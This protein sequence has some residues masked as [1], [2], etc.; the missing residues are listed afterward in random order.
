M[1]QVQPFKKKKK[2]GISIT[3]EVKDLNL[4]NY[5]MLIKEIK[6]YTNRWK[7]CFHELEELVLLKDYIT[8]GNLQI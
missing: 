5:K 2:L 3:K 1:M 6:D 7:D 4:E 8:H